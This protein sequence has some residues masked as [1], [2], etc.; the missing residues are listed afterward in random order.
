ME[1]RTQAALKVSALSI[2]VNLILSALKLAAGILARSGAMI[3]DALHSASDVFSTIIVM[4]GLK[5]SGKESDREH[6]YGH[7]RLECVAAILLSGILFATGL[8]IAW[9]AV[10][11][12]IAG[13]SHL[14]A[15][16][17][18]ALL[19]ALLS[20]LVKELLFHYVRRQAGRL[21]SG[22]LLAEAWHHRSDALSSVGALIG[23]A[24][25]RMGAPILDPL[26]S[27]VICVFIGKAAFDIFMDAVNKMVD[28]SCSQEQEATM[29]A[30][31]EAYTGVE[32]VD[33][34]R[35][36]EFGNRIYIEME[37]AVDGQVPLARAH[38]VAE[39]L[40]DGIE[41]AFPEVKHVMIHV[42]PI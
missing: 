27:V 20:I 22:A 28:H 7:E 32:R 4:I 33:L 25:A 13:Q 42:N 29:R 5:L 16:G 8:L 17:E 21:D 10:K 31:A 14:H 15:P 37:I 39:G 23:I 35:T 40:H 36:R 9:Q 19:A 34:L 12:I 2:V 18:L 26:A 3:S 6:P 38:E 11:K 41:E 24:G 1:E 30:Y